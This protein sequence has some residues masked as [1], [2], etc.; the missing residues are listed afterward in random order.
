[1]KV[2]NVLSALFVALLFAPLFFSCENQQQKNEI[3]Y[4]SIVVATHIPLLESND[5]TLP[6]SEVNIRFKYPLKFRNAEDLERLQQIFIGTFF[7]DE[8]YG[9]Y[10]LQEALDKYL[11]AYSNEYKTLAEDFNKEKSE[12]PDDEIPAWY[13]YQM[14]NENEILFQNDSLLSYVVF[15]FD[16]TG[17]AHGGSFHRTY[18]NVNLNDLVVLSEDDLFLPGYKKELTDIL[19]KQ[20]MADNQVTSPDSL[21]DKGFFNIEDIVPNG[22]F[23]I[24]EEGL[25]YAFN[26]YEIAPYVMGLIEVTISFDK[27][28]PILKP[29]SAI[30][31]T[32]TTIG[33]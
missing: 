10:Q 32:T 5:T 6:Y 1:M 23:W 7:G 30:T 16:Y 33:I 31:T 26:Q 21:I 22:N 20:L 2:K 24:N 12:R 29:E 9:M 17:G 28:L 14:S 18:Y 19:L 15:Y 8:Q 25:H 11:E 13:W 4:D 3:L 27:L